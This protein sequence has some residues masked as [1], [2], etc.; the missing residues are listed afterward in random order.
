MASRAF[1][2]VDLG[3]MQFLLFRWRFWRLASR[4]ATPGVSPYSTRSGVSAVI[5]T[6]S[7]AGC[8]DR[9]TRCAGEW[10]PTSSHRI[11]LVVEKAAVAGRR[12]QPGHAH[13]R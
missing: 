10:G 12:A 9:G 13:D 7:N 11:R 5:A 1:L 8:G 6:W 3:L 2:S 4:L